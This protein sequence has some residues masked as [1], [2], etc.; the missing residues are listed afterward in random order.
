MYVMIPTS[1]MIQVAG[2]CAA[3]RPV[4]ER[5]LSIA[6]CGGEAEAATPRKQKED[7]GDQR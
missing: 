3:E 4:C 7:F 5:L 2:P 6:G 1:Q